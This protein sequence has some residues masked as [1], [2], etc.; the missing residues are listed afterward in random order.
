MKP[1]E[2]GSSL[3][4]WSLAILTAVGMLIGGIFW[5]ARF[6]MIQREQSRTLKRIEESLVRIDK[7][8][9]ENDSRVSTVIRRLDQNGIF[10]EKD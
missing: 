1:I 4:D 6:P 2:T 5:I 10:T 7:R 8:M 3:P 9:E